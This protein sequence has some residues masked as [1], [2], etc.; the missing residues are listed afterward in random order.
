MFSGKINAI[1][2]VLII[3][4]AI[5]CAAGVFYAGVS[6]KSLQNTFLRGN[7]RTQD[8]YYL[9]NPG[10]PVHETEDARGSSAHAAYFYAVEFLAAKAAENQARGLSPVPDD[11]FRR[12]LLFTVQE[13][14]LRS[15]DRF[16][17]EQGRM[18]LEELFNDSGFIAY[19]ETMD[20]T[21]SREFYEDAEFV[22]FDFLNS[23]NRRIGSMGI[24]K[25]AGGI[26]L[27]DDEYVSL[28]S[29]QSFGPISGGI[30]T[31]TALDLNTL[32]A[33]PYERGRNHTVLISGANQGLTDTLIL[34]IANAD[35]QTI[36]LVSLPRDLF[37]RDRK[38]NE[39]Y[40]RYG[41]RQLVREME[42]LTGFD[43]DNYII[44][45]MYAFI[46]VINILG[47]IEIT[48]NAPLVDPTYR[49]RDN[50]NWSTLFYPAGTHHLNG[51]EA[52]RVARSRHFIMDFGRS[53][54]QQLILAAIFDKLTG[55]GVSDIG[56]VYELAMVFFQYVE[57]DYTPQDILRNIPRFRSARIQNQTVIDTGNILYSSYSN[58]LRMGLEIDEV[59]EDFNL[60]Q[61]IL[62][63]INDD[64][65]LI[66]RFIRS[67]IEGVDASVLI[68]QPPE[69]EDKPDDP[70][71]MPENIITENII[72]NMD[73]EIIYADQEE[74]EPDTDNEDESIPDD[75][76][77]EDFEQPES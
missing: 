24:Q 49:I 35:T 15:I 55:F 4:L 48:L 65:S 42:N 60:G 70:E 25:I 38:I 61:Y 75:V 57:T 34:A 56:R 5:I 53:R 9:Q 40:Y 14:P 73:T 31:G 64:W 20:L 10:N 22:F 11:A 52:L 54:H 16:F 68:S 72:D 46:D 37:Y 30:S 41:P 32:P 51:I 27:F 63:P 6:L 13:L 17:V 33:G 44:I 26:Y 67:I 74:P 18:Q 7:Q 12:G 43:I 66:H 62:L 76:T 39:I 28:G 29:I 50:G 47:G 8:E 71:D 45:D 58:L 1:R 2:M 36:D 3:G 69:D 21:L 23:E 77:H 59:D 19:L